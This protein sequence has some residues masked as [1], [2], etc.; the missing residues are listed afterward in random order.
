VPVVFPHFVLEVF[1]AVKLAEVMTDSIALMPEH[2][3]FLM[4]LEAH[5]FVLHLL[6][7]KSN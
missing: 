4:N 3:A 5:G 2:A 7:G 1:V 6:L